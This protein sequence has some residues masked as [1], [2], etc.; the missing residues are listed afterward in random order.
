[1]HTMKLF[2]KLFFVTLLF[3][4]LGFG[5]QAQSQTQ[6]VDMDLGLGYDPRQIA[7][8]WD[9]WFN[10]PS[11]ENEFIGAFM[12]LHEVPQEGLYGLTRLETWIWWSTHHPTE[13]FAYINER[14]QQ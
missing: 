5:V 11:S 10:E 2:A 7:E 9:D 12:Q 4:G 3:V 14:D 1:M 6:T 8:E 13:V